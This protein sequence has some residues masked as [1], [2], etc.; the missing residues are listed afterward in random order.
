MIRRGV[1]GVEFICMN[2][3]SGALQRSK[4]GLN[5]QLWATGLGAG[6]VSGGG[7]PKRGSR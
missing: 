2:T 1:Q 7:G 4:A 6:A 3:D 5:I